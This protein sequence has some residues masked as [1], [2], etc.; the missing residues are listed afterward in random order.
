MPAIKKASKQKLIAIG[1]H[2]LKALSDKDSITIWRGSPLPFVEEREKGPKVLPTLHPAALMRQAKLSSVVV[3]DLQKSLILPPENY[4]LYP[5]LEEVEEFRAKDFAF[6]LEWNTKTGDIT[7]CGLCDRHYRVLVVPF[8]EPFISVLRRKFENARS[9]I[10]HNIINADLPQLEKLGWNME[11]AIIHDTMLKQHLVQPDYPHDLGFVA[12]VFTNKVFW[13]GKGKED[14]DNG[15]EESNVQWK[16]WDKP[17]A[18]PREHGGYGGCR[19]SEEAYKLYNARD[20]DA[21]F[22][23]NTPLSRKLQQYKL[24]DTYW[25]VSR[26]IAYICRDLSNRGWKIDQQ[27]LQ[28]LRKGLDRDIKDLESSLPDGLRPYSILV[29]CNVKAPAGTYKPKIK[30]HKCKLTNTKTKLQT[31][32]EMEFKTPQTQLCPNCGEKVLPPKMVEAKIIKSQREEVVIPYNSPQKIQDYAKTKSLAEVRDHKT[33]R[34]TTG[35]KARKRWQADHQEFYALGELKKLVTLRDNFA[36]DK[37]LNEERMYFNLKVHGTAEGRLSSTGK[38]EGIDL[39]IQNQP[40]SFRKIY[41]PDEPGWA[42]LNLDIVQGENWL[43]TWL[44]KDWVRWERLQDPHYDEHSDLASRI[45]NVTITKELLK[46]DKYL[47]SLRQIGKKINHGRNYG[48]GVKKQLEELQSLGDEN[49]STYTQADVKEFIEIW[50]QLNTRTAAWQIETINLVKKQG[51]LEN[52]FGRRR[53]FQSR[54]FATKALAFLPASTLADM[55][56]RMMIAHY[57][58]AYWNEG[59]IK[60]LALRETLD[61]I[62]RWRMVAQV[63]DSIVLMGPQEGTTLQ[64]ARSKRIMTQKWSQLDEFAFKVESKSSTESWGDC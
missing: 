48:M 1:G 2:A 39:N 58:Y 19:S 15:I 20:V 56:L 47:K 13:K 4:N 35:N 34:I 57:P 62:P 49:L 52:P 59:V 7:I 36:K 44:A 31:I 54:D 55:V 40:E 42:I 28:T 32:L 51:Y 50:K 16:S 9:L 29:G 24:D 41:I 60:K 26:P 33:G 8:V 10:G 11:R 37:L 61:I 17:Y 64:E 12:S 21:E 38:R 45:F 23:I 25:N 63:H 18:I 6:D 22:Q 53:W 14:E 46:T 5:T 27:R 3:G 30:K 43:T